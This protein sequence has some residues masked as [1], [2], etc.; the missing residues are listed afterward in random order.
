MSFFLFN[1]AVIHCV[2]AVLVLEFFAFYT[3]VVLEV[4]FTELGLG[5]FLSAL[6]LVHG[7]VFVLLAFWWG[8]S[9]VA[10]VWSVVWVW[11][12]STSLFTTGSWDAASTFFACLALSSISVAF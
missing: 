1:L 10:H 8:L 11:G 3:G 2:N 12:F 7:S 6:G 5:A 9:P 4:A